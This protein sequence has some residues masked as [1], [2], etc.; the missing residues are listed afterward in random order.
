MMLVS[1]LSISCSN[2]FTYFEKTILLAQTY[3]DDNFRIIG[4]ARSFFHSS[5]LESVC[6]KTQN[7]VLCR[8]KGVCFLIGTLQVNSVNR[9]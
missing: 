4:Q 7:S 3:T 1:C 6:I 9:S 2:F 5:V 8:Q